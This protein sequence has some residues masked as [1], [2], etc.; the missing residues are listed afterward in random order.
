MAALLFLQNPKTRLF[1]L[2]FLMLFIEL[3]LIRFTSANIFY[4]FSLSNFILLASFLGIGLG[5]LRQPSPIRLFHFAP[6]LLL[7]IIAGCHYFSYEYQVNLN[8]TTDNL[9]YTVKA[10][11]QH[12]LPAWLTLPVVFIAVMLLM[13]FIAD[14]VARVFKQFSPLTAYRFEILGSLS[15]VCAF[16]LLAFFYPAPIYWGAIIVSLFLLLAFSDKKIFIYSINS[17]FLLIACALF[18]KETVAPNQTWSTYYKIVAEPF[19]DNR[20]AV[21]VNGLPQQ[22]I[23]SVEQRKRVKP[24]YFLPYIYKGT[25]TPLNNVLIVGAGT[26]GDVAIAL[27]KGAKHVDAVEIDPA[28]YQL[29][30]KLNPNQPYADKQVSIHINDG[31]AYLQQSKQQYD[32]IVF[33]LTDSLML[34]T[35]QSSLRLENYLYTLEGIQAVKNHLTQQGIFT[36]YNYYGNWVGDRLANTAAQV[37]K[38]SPC[39]QVFGK[40]DHWATVIVAGNESATLTCPQHFIPNANNQISPITDDRPF[41]YLK[42]N[43]LPFSYIITLAF[44]LIISICALQLTNKAALTIKSH[45]DLF[46]MGTAFLLLETKSIT[47]FALLFG[48]TWLVNAVVFTSILATVYIA[49]ELTHRIKLNQTI[50]CLLLITSLFIAW[51]VPTS[52]LLNLAWLPRF[53]VATLLAFAPILIANL[54]FADRFKQVEKSTLAFGANLIGAVLGGLLEYTSLMIG[55]HGLL[56]M[57]IGLYAFAIFLMQSA[58]ETILNH[59]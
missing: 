45:T 29:G 13:M 48:T 10:Y 34:L 21:N 28:L 5:F 22:I 46:L 11:Q 16:S 8:P 50:L 32:L 20:Y 31:R 37:F 49:I 43:K 56:V 30:V 41:L 7:L 18:F 53:F 55:Y 33:A 26:G 35:G 59:E 24:F 54:I 51:C 14:E 3:I 27:A 52:A 38:Q 39:Y 19:A 4:L 6:F 36:I 9:I 15:G 2:S 12:A 17:V 58:Q 57:I 44:I 42:E 40:K 1:L 47:Q 25:Q 23:E